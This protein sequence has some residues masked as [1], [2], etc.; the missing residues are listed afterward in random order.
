MPKLQLCHAPPSGRQIRSPGRGL[1]SMQ[2]QTRNH[3]LSSVLCTSIIIP[4]PAEISRQTHHLSLV[5]TMSSEQLSPAPSTPRSVVS[6]RISP[7]LTAPPPPRSSIFDEDR[8]S[9]CGSPGDTLRLPGLRLVNRTKNH[10]DLPTI[11]LQPRRGETG[12]D[13]LFFHC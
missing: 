10:Q 3:I 6:L 11:R 4:T 5:K 1:A 13:E 2:P 12:L 9:V 8:V 7:I